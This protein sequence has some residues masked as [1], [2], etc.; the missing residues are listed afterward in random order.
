MQEPTP[1]EIERFKEV[2]SLMHKDKK[3]NP[4]LF[5]VSIEKRTYPHMKRWRYFRR[6]LKQYGTRSIFW[7]ILE[8]IDR[9][10]GD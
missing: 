4:E 9:H 5:L 7:D 8:D 10:R 2:L 3:K 6:K 1:K